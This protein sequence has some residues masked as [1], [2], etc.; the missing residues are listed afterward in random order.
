MLETFPPQPAHIIFVK[1]KKKRQENTVT[2][3]SEK[4]SDKVMP[5]NSVNL[6]T[7]AW[8]AYLYCSIHK[9]YCALWIIFKVQHS[10]RRDE[11]TS[12]EVLCDCIFEISKKISKL[13]V[14]WAY[15]W[16]LFCCKR[17]E[18][19]AIIGHPDEALTPA[20]DVPVHPAT[21]NW[22]RPWIKTYHT[23]S[24]SFTSSVPP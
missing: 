19:P 16:N 2:I 7:L 5:N 21:G 9:T 11:I 6:G 4:V 17:S 10:S 14:V 22:M 24:I 13:D 18:L 15:H 23:L 8:K 3:S 12:A 20:P 1:K